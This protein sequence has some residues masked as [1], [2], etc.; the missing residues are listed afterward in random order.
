VEEN[1]EKRIAETIRVK[2]METTAI[3]MV[4]MVLILKF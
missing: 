4:T 2:D 3:A 1:S